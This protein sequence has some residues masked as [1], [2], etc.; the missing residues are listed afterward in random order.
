MYSD[1]KEVF[2]K[3]TF[4]CVLFNLIGTPLLGMEALIQEL[5]QAEQQRARKLIELNNAFLSRDFEKVGVSYT[6]LLDSEIN[7]PSACALI[8]LLRQLKEPIKPSPI[9]QLHQTGSSAELSAVPEQL[10]SSESSSNNGS[11]GSGATPNSSSSDNITYVRLQMWNSV[12]NCN[13]A[14]IRAD[15]ST[16]I[17]QKDE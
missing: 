8:P 13:S 9:E 1:A 7:A 3:L 15:A 17:S 16:V 12:S 6:A 10:R 4:Y 2:M 14:N 5:I 11:S